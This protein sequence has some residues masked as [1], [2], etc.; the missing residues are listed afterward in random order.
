MQVT[1]LHRDGGGTWTLDVTDKAA[2]SS[3]RMGGFNG[4]VLAD[5]LAAKAGAVDEP[6]SPAACFPGIPSRILLR[7]LVSVSVLH[8]RVAGRCSLARLACGLS[9]HV[10]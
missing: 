2:D 10:P 3:Q 1:A 4:I 8:P 6:L 7:Q 5:Y 9:L